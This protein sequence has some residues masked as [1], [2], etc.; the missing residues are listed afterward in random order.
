[1]KRNARWIVVLLIVVNLLTACSKG[2]VQGNTIEE[3][4]KSYLTKVDVD[5]SYKIA[6]VL[7][8]FKTNEK[9]G[10]RTAGSKAE[11]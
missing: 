3:L 9:L 10:Y 1:M 8:E 2:E 5:Y 4:N 6:K 11:I 7:E